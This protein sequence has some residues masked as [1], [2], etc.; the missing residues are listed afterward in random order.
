MLKKENQTKKKQENNP[1]LTTCNMWQTQDK[2]SRVKWSVTESILPN[3][4]LHSSLSKITSWH[5]IMILLLRHYQRVFKYCTALDWSNFCPSCLISTLLRPPPPP[6][7]K[8]KKKT[9]KKQ[10]KKQNKKPPK[11]QK[12]KKTTTTTKKKKEQLHCAPPSK[13]ENVWG[14]SGDH[15]YI[16]RHWD[17]AR[18]PLE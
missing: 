4:S 14:V 7:P 3:H 2:T 5:I 17:D 12:N 9:T 16:D 13:G 8:K 11:K 1:W 6:P 15:E 10:K 18:P